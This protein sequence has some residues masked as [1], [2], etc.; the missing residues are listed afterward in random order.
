MTKYLLRT[1]NLKSIHVNTCSKLICEHHPRG[2]KVKKSEL[3]SHECATGES[4]NCRL[5]LDCLALNGVENLVDNSLL[6]RARR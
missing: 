3:L 1:C 6:I 4:V 5:G 2:W